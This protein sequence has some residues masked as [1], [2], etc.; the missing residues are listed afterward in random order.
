MNAEVFGEAV[1]GGDAVDAGELL[2]E[3]PIF[4]RE[5]LSLGSL[6]LFVA[7]GE[8]DRRVLPSP[9]ENEVRVR[10]LDAGQVV[11]LVGLTESRVPDRRRRA[12]NS[13]GGKS[14]VKSGTPSCADPAVATRRRTTR[15]DVR[16]STLGIRRRVE[17][18]GGIGHFLP[19]PPR[20]RCYGLATAVP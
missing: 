13:S 12:L 15:K 16:M 9:V 17:W 14:L 20:G 10:D 18:C 3:I 5:H 8:V 6:A 19:P 1:D 4:K 2:D 11:E 7:M